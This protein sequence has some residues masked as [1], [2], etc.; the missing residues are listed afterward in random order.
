MYLKGYTSFLPQSQQARN[1]F[2]GYRWYEVLA[3]HIKLFL[4]KA[5]KRKDLSSVT[6]IKKIKN[7]KATTDVNVWINESIAFLMITKVIIIF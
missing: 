6:M 5:L 2:F 3:K 1:D 4:K 7:V